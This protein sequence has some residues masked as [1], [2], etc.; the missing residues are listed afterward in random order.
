MY[1]NAIILIVVSLFFISCNKKDVSANKVKTE[2]T[3]VK[4][5]IEKKE[6]VKK[7]TH[8]L[9]SKSI[10]AEFYEVNFN[11]K[12]ELSTTEDFLFSVNVTPK[13][14]KHINTAFPL[15][16]SF[17]DSCFKFDKKKFKNKDTKKLTD[18]ELQFELKSK[19]ESK[20][21][22]EIK[23]VLKF[24]YCDDNLCYN[25]NSP[26]NFNINVK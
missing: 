9:D 20:G 11:L 16:L 7:E 21:K 5:T 19:C 23:G 2:N 18:T 22:Q 25:Y 8:K 17:E 12:D 26:F 4:N 3:K 15:S 6:E 14:D 13:K 24:G 1:K 10:K